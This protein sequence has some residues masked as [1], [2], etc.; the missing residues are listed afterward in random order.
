[1]RIWKG[2]EKEISMFYRIEM[3][4]IRGKTVDIPKILDLAVKHGINH[5]YFGAGKVEFEDF[6][7]LSLIPDEYE[8]IIETAKPERLSKV[9][10][11][12]TTVY[13]IELKEINNNT[14]IKV[15]T[16]NIISTNYLPQMHIKNKLRLNPETLM[17]GGDEFLLEDKE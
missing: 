17:Y 4:F 12:F 13:R 11:L 5:L 2:K 6:E 10:R 8:V 14:F 15:E 7:K 1:M 9:Q 3:L 16:D